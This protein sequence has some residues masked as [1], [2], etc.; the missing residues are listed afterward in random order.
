VT[1][2]NET[3]NAGWDGFTFEEIHFADGDL[4]ALAV[5]TRAR[6]IAQAPAMLEALRQTD[7]AMS[8]A[9]HTLGVAIEWAAREWGE[10]SGHLHAMRARKSMLTDALQTVRALLAQIEGKE[11]N[12]H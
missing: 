10:S 8:S 9:E 12:A 4:L 6:L 2:P 7:I 3:G 11:V 1:G 5:P